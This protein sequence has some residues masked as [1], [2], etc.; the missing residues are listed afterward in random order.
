MGISVLFLDLNWHLSDEPEED[1]DAYVH[2]YLEEEIKAEALVKNLPAFSRFLQLSAL[3]S[4]TTLNFTSIASDAG[5]SSMTLR[6]YYQNGGKQN[7]KILYGQSGSNSAQGRRYPY[8]SLGELP[9]AALGR[10]NHL[11]SKNQRLT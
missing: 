9:Q 11:R 2:T 5:V 7:R 6:E 1:L 10:R 4:G 8:S 3:T